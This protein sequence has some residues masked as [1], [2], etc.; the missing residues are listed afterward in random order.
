[1]G[2]V[3]FLKQKPHFI[4]PETCCVPTSAIWFSI[5]YFV[6]ATTG[7]SQ[8]RAH[9]PKNYS[10]DVGWRGL[11]CDLSPR[12]VWDRAAKWIGRFLSCTSNSNTFLSSL[13]FTGGNRAAKRY[14]TV[15][16]QALYF[17]KGCELYNERCAKQDEGSSEAQGLPSPSSLSKWEERSSW[18]NR[19]IPGL[20]HD[21][22]LTVSTEQNWGTR[23]NGLDSVLE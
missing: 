17:W 2:G 1:M 12:S 9:P 19:T 3:F 23:D 16:F 22:W 5:I 20:S 14:W 4:S 6:S 15:E 18:V 13:T 11:G 7:A 10:L 8:M 21:N